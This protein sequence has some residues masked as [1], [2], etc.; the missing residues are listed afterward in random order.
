MKNTVHRDCVDMDFCQIMLIWR[1]FAASPLRDY[2]MEIVGLPAANVI[3]VRL[4]FSVESCERGRWGERG[5]VI[6]TRG[7]HWIAAYK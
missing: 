1:S 4:R 3:A 6:V 5:A 7:A 2:F